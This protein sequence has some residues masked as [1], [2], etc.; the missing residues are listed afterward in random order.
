VVQ[1]SGGVVAV[2]LYSAIKAFFFDQAFVAVVGEGVAVAVFVD[3]SWVHFTHHFHFIITYKL[4][5]INRVWLSLPI[6]CGAW[7]APY[8]ALMVMV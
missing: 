7:N 6:C 5:V 3:Q 2:G 8:L 1:V 4:G